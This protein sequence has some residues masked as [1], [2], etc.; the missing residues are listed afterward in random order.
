MTFR[1]CQ[2]QPDGYC[3]IPGADLK[4]RDISPYPNVFRRQSDEGCTGERY[5]I[6]VGG[7]LPPELEPFTVPLVC[8]N[9]KSNSVAVSYELCEFGYCIIFNLAGDGLEQAK[10]HIST[11]PITDSD[12]DN[13]NFN[14]YCNGSSCVVP[15]SEVQRR[16]G[17][18]YSL[19]ALCSVQLHIALHSAVNGQTCWAD[20]EPIGLAKKK[21]SSKCKPKHT[22]TQFSFTFTCEETPK[23]C[24]CCQ[25]QFPEPVATCAQT[26]WISAWDNH[27]E[28]KDLGCT[29]NPG[30]YLQID[31]E[32]VVNLT[33]YYLN[34][35]ANGEVS[36]MII[37][38]GAVRIYPESH[39]TSCAEVIVGVTSF[40]PEPSRVLDRLRV[41]ISCENPAE[42]LGEDC[43][44]ASAYDYDSECL[45]FT[46]SW[47]FQKCNLPICPDSYYL[48]AQVDTSESWY[49]EESVPAVCPEPSCS[50]VP[51]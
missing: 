46:S 11:S 8:G 50:E 44:N 20:G 39:N 42:A 19:E 48:V 13:F 30:I 15:M 10:L 18:D 37:G 36:N 45:T 34:T 3:M 5:P 27:K 41:H 1:F 12:I 7:L 51:Q 49:K 26:A 14:D 38:Q 29:S 28:L 47:S 33:Y 4:A 25:T 9:D 16:A 40:E 31:P 22:A 24:C 35:Y 32:Q 23:E 43:G 17:I 6:C 21:R 2:V